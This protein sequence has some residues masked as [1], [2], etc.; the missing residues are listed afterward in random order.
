[1]STRSFPVHVI[2]GMYSTE[3]H[4]H[5]RHNK[6]YR[7]QKQRQQDAHST[8]TAAATSGSGGGGRGSAA[9]LC[10][11]IVGGG[12]IAGHGITRL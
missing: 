5:K 4:T 1:M 8:A 7:R 2:T 3:E 10:L 9:M 6:H 12:E 11:G